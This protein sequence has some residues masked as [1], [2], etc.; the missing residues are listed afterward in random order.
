MSKD[1]VQKS[2]KMNNNPKDFKI[3]FHAHFEINN[4]GTQNIPVINSLQLNSLLKGHLF[5][6]VSNL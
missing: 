5:L 1:I 4:M 6:L 2:H 3:S